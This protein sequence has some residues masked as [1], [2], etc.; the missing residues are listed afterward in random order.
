M[1]HELLFEI[2]T[3]ELPAGYIQPALVNM[4]KIVTNQLTELGLPHGDIKTAATPRRLTICVDKLASAQK[5]S[6]EEV[7][8]PPKAAAFDAEGKPTKAAEGFAK[9]R[10]VTIEDIQIAKTPKGE[11]LMVVVE[12]KGKNTTALLPDLLNKII[13]QLPFPKSMHWGSGSATFARP[14]QWLVARYGDQLIPCRVND[15]QSGLT[16]RGHRFMSPASQEV[17]GFN[18]YLDNLRKAHVIADMEE[19]KQAVIKE[20]TESAKLAGGMVMDDAELVDTVT[21]LVEKPHAVCG[22]FDKKFLALPREV[23]ITSMREH[24]KY[25]AIVD[26]N[27]ELLPNFIAV[28]NTATRDNKLAVAGHQRVLRARLEDA[29]F[30][31]TED[32]NQQLADRVNKLSGVVFQAGLGTMLEKTERI[33]KLAEW[34]AEIVAP[35]ASA[36]AKRAAQLAK[37]DLITELVNEFPSLQGTMGR[38]YAL[39]DKEPVAVAQAIAEHYLPVRAG[40]R[41]PESDGGA[42]VGL[43]DRIDTIAGCFAIGKQPTGTT[44][45]YGL[46][47]LSLGLLHII[48]D[49]GYSLSLQE[50]TTKAIE[51]YGDKA[52]TERQSVL[53]AIINFIRGRYV[54]DLIAA[55]IPAPAIEAVTSVDFDDPIDCSRRIEALSA[56]QNEETFTILAGSFKRVRNIIKDHQEDQVNA[57]L[58]AEEA[59]KVLYNAFLKVAAETEPMLKTRN[60]QAAMAV[61]LE[62]KEPVDRF[63]DEVMVMADDEQIRNNRLALLTAISHL[64]LRIGDFSKMS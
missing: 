47:R 29:L 42:I 14:I 28:N 58:L 11:Y 64:F 27:D 24:Q 2:G 40:S 23:L 20:I 26:G 57:S 18:S 44:D 6:R 34:L 56:V 5:D 31:F 17:T 7:T 53:E 46:R 54:N 8:G 37:A 25:F 49:R 55:G 59:E 13:K 63:F 39:L 41:L 19:R 15:I 1:Q 52:S 30:F 38:A 10:G 4:S 62:M 60:Y 43:A 35:P 16:T 22:E 36:T 9:S 61:I 50:L 33:A 3:E 12:K 45:Q 48:S 21:N 32:Q 51:L